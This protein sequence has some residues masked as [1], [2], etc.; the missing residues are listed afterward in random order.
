MHNMINYCYFLMNQ[1][2]SNYTAENKR[3]YIKKLIYL[4]KGINK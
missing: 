3:N 1:G 2:S 4:I